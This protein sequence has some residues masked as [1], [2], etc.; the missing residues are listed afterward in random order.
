MIGRTFPLLLAAACAAGAC[1]TDPPITG[2]DRRSLFPLAVGNRWEFRVTA[3]NEPP[4]AKVQTVTGTTSF[5][6]APAF[7][8]ST[9]NGDK[10]TVSV[11]LLDGTKL[12]RASEI[13]SDAGTVEERIRFAPPALRVD[14]QS[15]RLGATYES[16]H[17]EEHLDESGAVIRV[18]AKRDTF[19]IEAVDEAITVPAGTFPCV[20]VRRMTEG[21]AAKTFWYARGVGKVREVGGQTEELVRA[22]VAAEEG[23]VE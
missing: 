13:G 12:V 17:T 6:G 2:G 7:V 22:D 14:T 5:E 11:Q 15:S 4:S 1:G 23:A 20:R 3:T 16:R 9:E 8:F 21:G 10:L 19:T 18:V